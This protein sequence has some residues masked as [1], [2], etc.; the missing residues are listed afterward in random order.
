VL[1]GNQHHGGVYDFHLKGLLGQED[2]AGPIYGKD[3]ALLSPRMSV[4]VY[5]FTFCNNLEHPNIQSV[6]NS[7]PAT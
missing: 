4:T 2:W 7:L 3:K 5:Q 1:N 6:S